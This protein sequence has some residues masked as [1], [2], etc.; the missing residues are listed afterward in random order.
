MCP[1]YR[2]PGLWLQYLFWFLH[3]GRKTGAAP[4]K[5]T[6]EIIPLEDRLRRILFTGFR[7]LA[8]SRSP[9]ERR[10]RLAW[11]QP[12]TQG[13]TTMAQGKKPSFK[14]SFI[15]EGEDGN[16]QQI[17]AVWST[18]NDKVFTGEITMLPLEA[19][20]TGKLRIAVQVFEP[21][22]DE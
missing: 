14:I 10:A 22:Q 17:G 18:K 13:D 19:L 15:P 11:G 9:C 2:A 12:E 1:T 16:W 21:K 8:P 7:L 5:K 6:G 20:A 3:A 4:P